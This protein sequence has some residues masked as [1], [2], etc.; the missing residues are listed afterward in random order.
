MYIKYVAYSNFWE[1][2]IIMGQNEKMW[3]QISPNWYHLHFLGGFLLVKLEKT[4]QL[5]RNL[6]FSFDTLKKAWHLPK[7]TLNPKI[8]N[9]AV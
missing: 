8:K 6:N 9:P 1:Y 3:L 7:K 2:S 4:C 5:R